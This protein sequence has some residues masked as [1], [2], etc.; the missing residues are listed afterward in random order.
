MQWLVWSK[1]IGL[2]RFTGRPSWHIGTKSM[3][4]CVLFKGV[5]YPW[6]TTSTWFLVDLAQSP[7]KHIY[8][9]SASVRFFVVCSIW[10]YPLLWMSAHNASLL[11]QSIGSSPAAGLGHFCILSFTLSHPDWKGSPASW[12]VLRMEAI[13]PKGEYCSAMW[14]SKALIT[15]SG[16]DFSSSVGGWA[17]NQDKVDFTRAAVKEKPKVLQVK[18][19]WPF[20]LSIAHPSGWATWHLYLPTALVLKHFL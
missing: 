3:W 15:M 16:L 7:A 6:W 2:P 11:N 19:R 18:T 17:F 8:S 13:I 9:A 10:N 5:V 12:G 14:L 1:L 20:Y 4:L